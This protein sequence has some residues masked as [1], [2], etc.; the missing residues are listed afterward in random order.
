MLVVSARFSVVVTTGRGDHGVVTLPRSLLSA[1]IVGAVPVPVRVAACIDAPGVHEDP[2]LDLGP[3][4]FLV[5]VHHVAITL[6]IEGR[7]EGR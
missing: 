1:L 3:G 4:Q 5:L 7:K 6:G 2:S